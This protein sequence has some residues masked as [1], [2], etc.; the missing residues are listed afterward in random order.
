[1]SMRRSNEWRMCSSLRSLCEHPV[2]R[3]VH[4]SG[5]LPVYIRMSK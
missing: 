2:D 1:M 4:Y 5:A 3:S